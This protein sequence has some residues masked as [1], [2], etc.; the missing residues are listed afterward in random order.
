MKFKVF[1]Y[2]GIVVLVVI[3]KI[4]GKNNNYK[5]QIEI[6]DLNGN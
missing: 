1:G 6:L 3:G 2:G 5:T 4:I